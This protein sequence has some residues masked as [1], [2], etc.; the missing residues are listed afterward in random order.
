MFGLVGR[1]L[2][3][4]WS[5]EIHSL[6]GNYEY[7]LFEIEPEELDGFF[8]NAGFDGVNVT[9]PYKRD[10]VKFCDSLS[11][12][13]K[14][15][16]SVN[17]VI[18]KGDGSLFGDNTDY[19]GFRYLVK[20]SG[21]LLSG[22]DCYVLGT[23][24]A[25]LAVKA[26]LEDLRA[27]IFNVSRTGELNYTN[28]YKHTDADI[29]IN[30]TPVGMYPDCFESPVNMTVFQRLLAVYDIVYNPSRTQFMLDAEKDYVR[31]FGGLDM[32]V[33]QAAKS[34]ELFTGRKIG[35]E[36]IEQAV[37]SVR[38][39]KRNILIIGMPGCGKST[40]GRIVAE[41]L[42]REFVD[43][44]E[45]IEKKSGKSPAEIIKQ[46][47]E[48]AFREIESAVLEEF[49]TQSSKVIAC[50]GGVISPKNNRCY[51][52]KRNSTVIWIQRDEKLLE[53]EGRPLS[54]IIGVHELYRYREPLYIE[55]SDFNFTN[56]NAPEDC[57]AK[58]IET[59]ERE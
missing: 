10:V 6:F 43:L 7:R 23:G 21:V 34:S 11:E 2:K 37:R 17:T 18:R 33:A 40:V 35:E 29:L 59:L 54:Q 56:N 25:S 14:R 12:K 52:L 39:Q 24:G 44:D 26:V 8:R 55:S 45:E 47:G 57:A 4:S 3:H 53:T 48:P 51:G 5:P 27:N 19:D 42:G 28:L 15:I 30:T 16:G 36:K 31:A 22:K 49:G 1:K 50:G 46:E 32:L 41:R 58:I 9:I 20:R 13:A 38:N